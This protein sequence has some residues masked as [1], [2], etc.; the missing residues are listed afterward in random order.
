LTPKDAENENSN[1]SQS[2]SFEE[3]A[4]M[5]ASRHTAVECALNPAYMVIDFSL[6]GIQNP[7]NHM[8]EDK[9][10]ENYSKSLGRHTVWLNIRQGCSIVEQYDQ[11]NFDKLIKTQV[12]RRGLPRVYELDEESRSSHFSG[13]RR[14]ILGPVKKAIERG[15]QVKVSVS[16]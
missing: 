1:G 7:V 3:K 16:V 14:Q 12:L 9:A 5:N 4:F 6:S 2:L 15:S 10:Y 13:C 11:N 8:Q